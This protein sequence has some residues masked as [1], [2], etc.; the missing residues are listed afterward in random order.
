M[1]HQPFPFL[2]PEEI[3]DQKPDPR[4]KALIK[5]LVKDGLIPP[6]KDPDSGS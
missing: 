1:N 3:P 2:N 6:P 4:T 5:A